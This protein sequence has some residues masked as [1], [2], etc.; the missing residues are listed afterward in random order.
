MGWK[1]EL[2]LRGNSYFAITGLNAEPVS[3]LRREDD[4]VFSASQIPSN[5]LATTAITSMS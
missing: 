4:N 5:Y 2:D 3:F 1:L